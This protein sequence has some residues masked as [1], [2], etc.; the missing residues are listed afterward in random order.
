MGYRRAK[1]VFHMNASGAFGAALIALMT[2]SPLPLKAG[3]PDEED[4][5]LPVAPLREEVL[6][7]PGDAKRPVMI[8]VTLFTPPGS[9]PFPLAVMNHGATHAS[10]NS[11]G[12][13]YHRTMSAYYFLSRGYAVALPMMRGFAE[14]GGSLFHAGCD[15]AATAH[16]NAADITAVIDALATRADIDRS[17][18][19]VAGQSFGAWNA[20]GLGASPPSGV[21]GFVFFNPA[22]RASD[23]ATQDESMARAAGQF[24][25]E[26]TLPSI[27][28]Y[29]D[30]DMVMPIPVWRSV[31]DHYVRAGGQATLAAFGRFGDDSHQLLSDPRSLAIW[32]YK[33]DAFLAKVGLPSSV[34]YPD[35]LPRP[36]PPATNWA[37]LD[38]ASA[39]PFLNDK[40][41][42]L[43]QHFL[44]MTSPRV[45][46][47]AP[48]GAATAESGGY[49]PLG[50]GLEQCARS[51]KGCRPYA[52]NSSVVWSGSK[53][54]SG[55]E[56]GVRQVSRTVAMNV[57]SR[58][59]AFFNADAD[60][61]SRGQSQITI[62]EAPKHGVAE[63]SA[64]AEHPA[65]PA[66]NPQA[67]CNALAIPSMVVTYTPQSGYSGA[68]AFTFDEVK[69]DGKHQTF[70]MDLNVR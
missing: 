19:I 12:E 64:H 65:F 29:G 44:S 32:A 15:L 54:A 47:I 70:R 4:S 62:L 46:V 52:V 39:V 9:G 68:D 60:C 37:G 16:A 61:V 67:K 13:R 30:N 18:I 31:F 69:V 27:W 48:N 41:R 50:H 26:A 22:L 49:D 58:L 55:V 21:R 11:R 1:G 40:G 10:A 42:A 28:F 53:A 43:Y 5:S 7:L 33:V 2:L 3:A 14:S 56:P 51:N 17:R 8:E 63:A 36:F 35:Y 57:G 45:F 25:R 66:N 59:G 6:K 38:D 20:L 34:K 23:C 24:G